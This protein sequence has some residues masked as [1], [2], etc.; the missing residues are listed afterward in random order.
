M[1]TPY[2]TATIPSVVPKHLIEQVVNRVKSE[3]AQKPAP[4]VTLPQTGDKTDEIAAAIG[5]SLTGLGMMVSFA[6]TRKKR[7]E[8]A[9]A[10]N[11][12]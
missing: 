5:A 3:P 7:K 11:V 9:M 2:Q 6:G 1:P 4:Q 12:G 8:L 10:R